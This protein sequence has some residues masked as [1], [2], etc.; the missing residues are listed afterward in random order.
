MTAWQKL[1]AASNW[2]F[3]T[4][5]DL[6][7]HPGSGDA[8]VIVN[9][10][11]TAFVQDTAT[12]IVLASAPMAVAVSNPTVAVTVLDDGYRIVLADRAT[13]VALD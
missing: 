8:G 11:A 10:G 3:G 1:L 2:A 4:A 5:W 13:A 6:I 12:T 7:T 9:N